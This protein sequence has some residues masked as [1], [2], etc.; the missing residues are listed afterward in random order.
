MWTI[1]HAKKQSA[2]LPTQSIHAKETG[3]EK[4][5]EMVSN[6]I[7]IGTFFIVSYCPPSM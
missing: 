7:W 1:V 3:H 4:G 5:M 2:E 6:R